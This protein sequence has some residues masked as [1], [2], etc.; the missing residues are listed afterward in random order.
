[1]QGVADAQ[2]RHVLGS[3]AVPLGG[4]TALDSGI[5]QRIPPLDQA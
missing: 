5:G 3:D 1:V 4:A 2:I